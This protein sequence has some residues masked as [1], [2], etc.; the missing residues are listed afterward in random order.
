MIVPLPRLPRLLTVVLLSALAAQV[1]AAPA[2][3]VWTCAL[4]EDAKWENLT[5]LGVLLVGTNSAIH[6]IDPDTGKVLWKNADFKKSN[7]MNAR[8]IPGTPFLLCNQLEGIGG[9]KSTL[10]LIDYLT[11][12]TEWTAPEVMGQY[13]GS[14]PLPEK[15]L[16]IVIMTTYKDG[17]GQENGT[18]LFAHDLTT[19]ERKWSTLLAKANSIPLHLADNSGKFMPRMDLSGYHD[20]VL[21]GDTLYLG[22]L[23]VHALDVNTGA[24]KWAVEFPPGDKG[25]KRTY[26]PLRIVGDVIYGAGGGSIHA[27]NKQTGAALWKSDRISEYAGLF[28][29][30]DNAIVTQIEVV[31]DKIYARYGGNFSNG[32][33]VLLKEPLGVVVVAAADGKPLY[34]DKKIE[35]GLTNLMPL[36]ET[37]AVMFADGKELVGLSTGATV[38][39]LFRV[40]IEFKRKMGGGDFAKIGLGLTGGL[41]GTV[42]A[43]SSSSKARLD[44][45]V[46][47]TRHDGHI[48]VQG[49]QH[50]LGF[51]PAGKAQ[52]W[53][54]YYAAPSD[55]FST[56]AMFAVT[57]AA[58]AQGN[59]QV[60]QNGSIMTSGGQQGMQ[61]IQSSLDRYNRYTETRALKIGGSKNSGSYTYII[62]KLDKQDGG[63]VGLVGVNLSSGE[64]D[65]KLALGAKE[66]KYLADEEAGRIFYFKGGDEIQAFEF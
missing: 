29:S 59:A 50:L 19:G 4:G 44:V 26:A 28:K 35:G 3:P 56:I 12:E 11:G 33:T 53:S 17:K 52:K 40:P 54:L 14:V 25:L 38:E 45:P 22:Y 32:Q 18:F 10:T 16:V 39:E 65:R 36:P 8:E 31:A 60:A 1:W 58:S 7:S 20:P 46:A 61:N 5:A 49:K 9:S 30:R 2:K 37:G 48:V 63:G 13:L 23:G 47:I 27:I 21:E 64:T 62:T 15:N 43:V 66:P 34:Q 24:I 41:M 6:C 42:K 51:D 55:A 57:L